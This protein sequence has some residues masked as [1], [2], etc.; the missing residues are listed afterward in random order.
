LQRRLR[1]GPALSQI[2]DRNRLHGFS[3]TCFTCQTQ[4]RVERKRWLTL[5][6]TRRDLNVRCKLSD[7]GAGPSTQGSLRVERNGQQDAQ[8]R[9]IG[10]AGGRYRFKTLLAGNIKIVIN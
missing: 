8:V 9:P 4:S 10:P 3:V 6:Q 5:C 1:L 2:A 7:E